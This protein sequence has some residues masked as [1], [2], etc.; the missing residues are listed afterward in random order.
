[1]NKINKTFYTSDRKVWRAWLAENFAKEAEIWLVYPKQSSGQ[2]CI[3]YNDAVEEALCFG[4]IDSIIKTLD[5]DNRVQRFTPRNPNS[6]FSQ[7][8]KERLK[9]LVKQN[10]LHP[11]VRQKAKRVIREQFVVPTDVVQAIQSDAEAWQHYQ[12]FS[13]AYQRI[14]LAYIASA[15]KRPQEF[16]KRL[17]HFIKKTKQNKQ[18]G[19]GGIAK[20]F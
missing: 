12:Q 2:P 19:Y 16:Q 9:W 3:L 14:R 20:Y 6:S 18:F 10:M 1:M 13:A 4:W 15:R 17:A 5:A 11:S 8:N 7:Q